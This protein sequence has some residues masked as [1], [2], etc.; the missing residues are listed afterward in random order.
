MWREI[1]RSLLVLVFALPAFAQR[2]VPCPDVEDRLAAY[3]RGAEFTSLM[4]RHDHEPDATRA[5]F[6]VL[7]HRSGAWNAYAMKRARGEKR[8]PDDTAIPPYDR[9]DFRPAPITYFEGQPVVRTRGQVVF[10]LANTNVALY[11]VEKTVAHEDVPG[12]DKLKKI[13]A[14]FAGLA[15][16]VV[17][18]AGGGTG[19]TGAGEDVDPLEAVAAA[20]ETLNRVT[21]AVAA[22]VEEA[23]S[24]LQYAELRLPVPPL[25][26]DRYAGRAAEVRNAIQGLR[27]AV[28]EFVD[29]P[30][31]VAHSCTAATELVR[32]V[33]EE[34]MTKEKALAGL[35]GLENTCPAAA[36]AA[37]KALRDAAKAEQYVADADY[38]AAVTKRVGEALDATSE[39]VKSVASLANFA[40][41]YRRVNP[42]N[43]PCKLTAGILVA[44]QPDQALLDQTGLVTVTIS[45][46]SPL[47]A[48]YSRRA[49]ASGDR[50]YRISHSATDRLAYGVGIVHTA[51][52]DP[53]FSPIEHPGDPTKKV[54]ARTGE[55]SRT[56]DLALLASYRFGRSGMALRPGIQ[57]GV[58]L[59]DKTPLFLGGS[60]DLGRYFRLGAG[61][62]GQRITALADGYHELRRNADG[63]VDPTSISVIGEG[64][65]VPTR[66]RLA[67]GFYATLVVTLDGIPFFSKNEE[68]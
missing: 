21:D 65:E 25:P 59:S 46:V 68:E 9:S 40:D 63:S 43:D 28:S 22:D 36:D 37:T 5:A 57:F 52:K 39:L 51:V 17:T 56:G 27:T 24:T 6:M 67:T 12:L 2:S 38:F 19:L 8:L 45:D 60:L 4:Q 35:A 7:D 62:T 64:D 48:T 23:T 15:Q 16:Q 53:E 61:I 14:A 42:D 55:E 1:R 13:I 50:K 66:D 44:D 49:D 10:A 20:M 34:T 32:K 31:V 54:V 47:G 3:V 30:E 11:A 33:N 58:G 41:A 26:L 18:R 29:D